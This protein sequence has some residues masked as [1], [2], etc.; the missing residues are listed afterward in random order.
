MR[1]SATAAAA[2]ELVIFA[3][4]CTGLKN[5]LRYARKTVSAPTVIASGDDQRRA[6][7]EHERRAQR[8]DDGHHRR[9]QRLDPARLERRVDGRLAHVRKP[10]FLEILPAEGLDHAHRFQALLHDGD[11]VGLMQPH[12]V[13]ALS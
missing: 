11:D 12:L 3:R 5:L 8:D 6:A 7:P 1:S 2:I 4:S 9:E 10:R 13:R